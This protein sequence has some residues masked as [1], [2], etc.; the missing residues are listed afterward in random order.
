[1]NGVNRHAVQDAIRELSDRELQRR[2]WLSDGSGGSQVSSFI[3]AGERLFT[4][5]GLAHA[6]QAGKTV[7]GIEA[8]AALGEL[9]FAL[10]K[11]DY[12]HGPS[13]T[14]DDPAMTEV[15]TIAARLLGL[16]AVTRSEPS[17]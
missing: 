12:K 2:L 5:S 14:M 15:R 1:M 6:L 10:R 11:V 8:D 3:E 9:D 16:L 4:D 13:R 17:P 7:F